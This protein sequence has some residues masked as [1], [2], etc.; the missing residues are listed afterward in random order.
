M[1]E[2]DLTFLND[3]QDIEVLRS[4]LK[5]EIILNDIKTSRLAILDRGIENLLKDHPEMLPY[6]VSIDVRES[7]QYNVVLIRKT[8]LIGLG[9]AK[10][11]YD[12]YMDKLK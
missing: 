3:E 6:F 8:F 4:L 11:L 7:F 10:N 2:S 9:D 12:K 1:N 5:N